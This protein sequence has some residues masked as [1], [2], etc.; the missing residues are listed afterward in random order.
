M[1]H[2]LFRIALLS[3]VKISHL[4]CPSK[5]VVKTEKQHDLAESLRSEVKKH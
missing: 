3:P 4:F 5:F 2:D 1:G